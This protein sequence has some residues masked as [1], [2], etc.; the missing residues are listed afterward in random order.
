MTNL[1]IF[2]TENQKIMTYLFFMTLIQNIIYLKDK[3]LTD[4]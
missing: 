3:L 1:N 4:K 2:V